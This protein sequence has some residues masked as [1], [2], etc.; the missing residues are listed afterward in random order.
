MGV[1]ESMLIVPNF[2]IPVAEK[3]F[4]TSAMCFRDKVQWVFKADACEGFSESYVATCPLCGNDCFAY[5]DKR[6]ISSDSEIEVCGWLVEQNK[7]LILA[8]TEYC[9]ETQRNALLETLEKHDFSAWF[10]QISLIQSSETFHHRRKRLQKKSLTLGSL[11]QKFSTKK[12]LTATSTC[13]TTNKKQA[14]QQAGKRNKAS[15]NNSCKKSKRKT[16][17]STKL[18]LQKF[19][20]IA[21]E[22]RSV[23]HQNSQAVYAALFQIG[24]SWTERVKLRGG[25][26]SP[27]TQSIP[28]KNI[29]SSLS[30]MKF[31][32]LKFQIRASAPKQ[33]STK[34]RSRT[35]K[36]S[37]D[38]GQSKETTETPLQSQSDAE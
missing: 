5:G 38:V 36:K 23:K 27:K 18:L 20:Q 14:Q 35:A 32:S 28:T 22:E 8:V 2:K 26:S 10:S 37:L 6:W 34:S 7:T 1:S 4:L 29:Q 12:T 21:K 16:N 25:S 24:H 3:E 31:S 19:K 13:K 15:N 30:E 17:D 9:L 11:L 33:K